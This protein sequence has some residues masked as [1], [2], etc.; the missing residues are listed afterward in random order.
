MA[1]EENDSTTSESPGNWPDSLNFFIPKTLKLQELL[2]N[3]L[4]K[5]NLWEGGQAGC[6][7]E[8][9]T[10]L[11]LR[12]AKQW[13]LESQ[14]PWEGGIVWHSCLLV[15]SAPSNNLSSELL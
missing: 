8:T 10:N 5:Q 6:P 3:F 9:L 1:E 14:I 7:G 11:A 4:E 12:Q 15:S 2:R 13:V